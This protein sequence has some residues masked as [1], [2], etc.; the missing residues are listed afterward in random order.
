[1]YIYIYIYRGKNKVRTKGY[2]LIHVE[3]ATFPMV[4]GNLS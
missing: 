3:V 4:D 2:N 1:M